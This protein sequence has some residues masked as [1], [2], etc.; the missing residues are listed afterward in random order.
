MRNSDSPKVK[1][2]NSG[3][4]KFS[5]PLVDPHG[6]S[7]LLGGDGHP[8]VFKQL[9]EGED[10]GKDASVTDSAGPVKNTRL[11]KYIFIMNQE[12]KIHVYVSIHH[13]EPKIHVYG[14]IYHELHELGL[15]TSDLGLSLIH[16]YGGVFLVLPI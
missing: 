12:S 5:H 3:I 9:L 13:E 14:S 7:D 10:R 11:S 4:W 15:R 6:S 16:Y 2:A 1:N 8:L